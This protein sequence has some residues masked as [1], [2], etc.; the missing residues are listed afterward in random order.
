MKTTIVR[1]SKA[2]TLIELLVVIAIIA[3]LAAQLL[4]VLAKTEKNAR[5]AQCINNIKQAGLAL[6]VWGD[7]HGDNYPMAVSTAQGGAMENIVSRSSARPAG[8]GVTNVFCVMSN[9]LRTLKILYCPADLSMNNAVGA[10]ASMA[11]NWSAFGPG[12]LSYFV[13]GDA[14]DKYPKMILVGDRNIGNVIGGKVSDTASFGILPADAMNMQN[15]AYSQVTGTLGA[16]LKTLPW[17]WTDGDLHQDSGNLGMAD[18][19]VNQ[20][21]LNGL[22]NAITDTINARPGSGNAK[23]IVNIP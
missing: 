11:T 10:V 5:R 17:A 8:Y 7:E 13:E 14:S 21:S 6:K 23:I 4:P 1:P 18:G 9:E 19:S 15:A 12:N 2:F 3:V 22:K 20:A 16:R